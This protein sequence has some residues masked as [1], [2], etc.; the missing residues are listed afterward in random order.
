MSELNQILAFDGDDYAIVYSADFNI[1]ENKLIIRRIA[2][3]EIEFFF[4]KDSEQ[5][6]SPIEM[7]GDDVAKKLTITLYNF[8]NSLGSGM[9]KKVPMINLTDGR[10]IYF[11][12]HAKS[13]NETT[14]F[15]KVSVTFY[16]K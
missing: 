1:Y 8:N 12:L 3:Y 13:L 10:Q 2:G 15:L 5:V 4:K 16:V 11:S 7:K 9:T 6:G 14:P